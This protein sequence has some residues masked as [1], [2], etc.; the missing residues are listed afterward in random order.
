MIRYIANDFQYHLLAPVLLIPF[1]FNRRRLTY[2]ILSVLLLANVIITISIISTHPGTEN[3]MSSDGAISVDYFAKIYVTPWCRIGPFLIGMLTRL[4]LEYH[5][6][7]ISSMTKII[8]TIISI[9]LAMICIYFP[10]YSNNFPKILLIIYQSIS[11]QCWA[12]AIGWLILICCLNQGGLVNKILSWP[13]WTIIARLSYSAYLIHTIVILV[14][15]FNRISTIHYQT[16]VMANAFLAQLIWTLFLSIL[17]VI[18]VEMPCQVL[19]K[20]IRKSYRE[21]KQL[22]ILQSNY[23]TID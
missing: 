7:P 15:V 13:I 14:Q 16:S 23:G 10:F 9:I 17:V 21:K 19:E 1:I 3:G 5:R 8:C 4:I 12:L 22:L 20:Q 6:S 18:L 11:H 2:G